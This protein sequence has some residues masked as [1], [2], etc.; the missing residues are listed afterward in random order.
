MADEEEGPYDQSGGGTDRLVKSLADAGI[1][2]AANVYTELGSTWFVLVRRPREA[3]HVLG[4]LLLAVGEDNVLWGSDSIWYGSPQPLIDAFRAFQIPLELRELHGYPELTPRIKAKILGLNAARVYG[5]DP[6]A[7]R[8]R[9]AT[10]DLAWVKAALSEFEASRRAARRVAGA[11]TIKLG[12]LTG[13]KCVMRK[14]LATEAK[15][16]LAE[17][18]RSVEHGETVAI[19]RHGSTIAHLVP[20]HTH[21]CAD[22][23]AAVDRFLPTAG[24]LGAHRNVPRRNRDRPPRG[25]PRMSR[26]VLDASITADWLL[27]DEFDLKGRRRVDAAPAG[28]GD[29]AA[30]LA[31]R[32]AQ[33]AAG[34]GPSRPSVPEWDHG[35]SGFPKGIAHTHRR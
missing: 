27:D 17:L 20:A 12:K 8:Q 29:R 24:R 30:A 5:I 13:W 14:V 16:R 11:A 34:S 3:A 26:L 9:A 1:P 19:T 25:P 18:L 35:A 10:D 4:K 2:P 28:W 33:R 32:G 22:R 23:E 15:T 21:A 6:E 31:L 7:A